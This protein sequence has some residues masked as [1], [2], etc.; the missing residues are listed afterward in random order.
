M[1]DVLES[2]TS[3]SHDVVILHRTVS[4][5]P[6]NYLHAVDAIKMYVQLLDADG[7]G[8]TA[9]L[10]MLV[11]FEHLERNDN[12]ND[13]TWDRGLRRGIGRTQEGVSDYVDDAKLYWKTTSVT[14][15]DTLKP[16]SEALEPRRVVGGKFRL[17]GRDT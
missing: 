14:V 2:G 13:M 16:A 6:E 3:G 1:S 17:G 4:D 8:R 12:D 9:F 7:R 5:W 11:H 10:I 15:L